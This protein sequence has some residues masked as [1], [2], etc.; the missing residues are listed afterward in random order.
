MPILLPSPLWSS[1]ALSIRSIMNQT[2][3]MSL[4]E[5]LAN[6]VVG[7]G[8]AV[9]TQVLLFPLFGFVPSLAQNLQIGMVFSAVSLVRSYAMRRLFECWRRMR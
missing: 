2:R 8:L 4:A 5:A 7:Y 3:L 9:L 6:L 1:G